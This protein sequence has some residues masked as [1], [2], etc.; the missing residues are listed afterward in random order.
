MKDEGKTTG[1]DGLVMVVDDQPEIRDHVGE[2]LKQEGY[3][4]LTLGGPEEAWKEFSRLVKSLSLVILDL[5]LG[6]GEREGMK[7]L[8]RMKSTSP[9]TPVVILTGKGTPRLAVEALKA[10][11]S[12][13]LEKG[14]YLSEH[15]QFTADQQHDGRQ[16]RSLFH[17]FYVSGILLS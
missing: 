14:V 5:D 10:G 8:K 15:L 12:D 3:Q 6:E 11:A 17:L 13:F 9:Q 4:A 7:L 1:Y 16:Q 2:I